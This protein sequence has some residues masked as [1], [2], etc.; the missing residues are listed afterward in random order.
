MRN[1]NGTQQENLFHNKRVALTVSQPWE[2][3]VVMTVSPQAS[4]RLNEADHQSYELRQET[5][6]K[7]HQLHRQIYNKCS[8]PVNN[9]Q[10]LSKLSCPAIVNR[11]I[12][13][14]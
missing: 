14:L 13:L 5:E 4:V 3:V 8:I 12:K 2:E 1:P 9:E 7:R 10:K 11:K 6:Q